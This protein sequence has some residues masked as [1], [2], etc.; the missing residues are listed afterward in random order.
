M[1]LRA[2]DDLYGNIALI[3]NKRVPSPA[4]IKRLVMNNQYVLPRSIH[5]SFILFHIVI[6]AASNYFV[7][8]PLEIAGVHNTWGAFVFPLILS[9]Q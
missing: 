5:A 8:F 2:V 1:I 3:I 7:Q 4:F 9:R 6:L